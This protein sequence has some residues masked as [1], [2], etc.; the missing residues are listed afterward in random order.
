MCG[1]ERPCIRW[2]R[3]PHAGRGNFE[4]EKGPAYDMPRHVQ[5][6]IY[7]K[8]LSRGQHQYGVD[9]DWSVLHC[10]KKMSHLWF[11]VTLTHVNEF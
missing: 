4:A 1:P 10:I 9:A 3:D 7:S 8:Q 11:A 2:G 6:L 5:R